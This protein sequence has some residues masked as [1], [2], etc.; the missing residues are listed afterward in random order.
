MNIY[1]VGT[2]VGVGTAIVFSALGFY[3]HL[4]GACRPHISAEDYKKKYDDL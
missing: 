3:A 2:L 4:R 1:I